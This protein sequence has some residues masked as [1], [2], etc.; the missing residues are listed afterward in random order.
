MIAQHY[1]ETIVGY[2]RIYCIHAI[3][4]KEYD[5]L[6]SLYF[7]TFESFQ[8]SY[9]SYSKGVPIFNKAV[10]QST[11]FC[12]SEVLFLS[13][14]QVKRCGKAFLWVT[15]TFVWVLAVSLKN[16]SDCG[17]RTC[18][19]LKSL[20]AQGRNTFNSSPKALLSITLSPIKQGVIN[21]VIVTEFGDQLYSR[22]VRNT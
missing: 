2:I 19:V 16:H 15:R 13:R 5:K 6:N 7:F 17:S 12:G 22:G 21:A 3:L 8:C 14:K 4:E 11:S 10:A 9:S 20:R 1:W 18:R